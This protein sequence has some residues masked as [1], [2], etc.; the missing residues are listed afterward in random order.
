MDVTVAINESVC[1][2]ERR[3]IGCDGQIQAKGRLWGG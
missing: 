1:W 2:G 3:S